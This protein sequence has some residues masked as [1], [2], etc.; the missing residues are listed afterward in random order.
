MKKSKLKTAADQR[1]FTIVYNDF[2]E[3]NLLDWNEK[4]I[5]IYLKKFSD[6][7]SQCFPSIKTLC[8][9]SQLSKKTVL[10]ALKGLEDKQIII[11]QLRENE[12]YGYQSNLYTLRDN[13]AMWESKSIEKLKSAADETDLE[14]S[15]RILKA[16]GYTITKE[17]EPAGEPT[18]AHTQT[19]KSNN[20][21]Q[22]DD[23]TDFMESQGLERYTLDQIKQIFDYDI[24][25]TD[26]SDHKMDINIV[27]TILYD[28]LNCTKS[29][30]RVDGQDKPS[31]IV[32]SRLMKLDQSDIWY[33]IDKYHKQKERIKNVNAYLLTILYHAKE[34]AY[35]DLMN[36]GHYNGDF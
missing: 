7:N 33:A 23:T 19:L 32:I 17:K 15:I 3:T 6:S 10:K 30:I 11:K 34:Q 1:P 25:I 28:T 13:K 24:I 26:H 4:R 8:T 27:F 29:V 16:A 18:K 14:K 9:L 5:F 22:S 31:M 2:L 20:F 35:L 12:Q 21:Y 36:L